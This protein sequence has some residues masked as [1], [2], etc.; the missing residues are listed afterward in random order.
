MAV[1]PELIQDVKDYLNI[2][3]SDPVTDRKVCGWIEAGMTYLDGKRGGYCDYMQPSGSRT[4][5]MDYTRYARDSALDVFENN[6]RSQILSMQNE[7]KVT[8]YVATTVPEK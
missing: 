6:F 3:W 7:R 1:S 4:L 8:S 5:L 2:T